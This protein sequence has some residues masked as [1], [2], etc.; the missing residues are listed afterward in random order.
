MQRRC[1]PRKREQLELSRRGTEGSSGGFGLYSG[2]PRDEGPT[3][4]R[5]LLMGPSVGPRAEEGLTPGQWRDMVRGELE[6]CPLDGGTWGRRRGSRA[7]A[8]TSGC[9]ARG[10]VWGHAQ[11]CRC[12]W[13]RARCV[14]GTDN[15][16]ARP[17]GGSGSS[18]SLCVTSGDGL[19][20]LRD[21]EGEPAR[22]PCSLLPA[23]QP[24]IGGGQRRLQ[25]PS[26]LSGSPHA[27]SLPPASRSGAQRERD[28]SYLQPLPLRWGPPRARFLGTIDAIIPGSLPQERP[29]SPCIC[30][31]KLTGNRTP[32]LGRPV[33]SRLP[34]D[35]ATPPPQPV[36]A[37]AG[38]PGGS[39]TGGRMGT[40]GCPMPSLPAGQLRFL[41]K[42]EGAQ[43]RQLGAPCGGQSA[44]SYH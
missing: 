3:G 10:G 21:R 14:A 18:V 44:L 26:A 20:Q 27:A 13:G 6:K 32:G 31:T 5:G 11:G 25:G 39:R 30:I 40:P 35:P 1:H 42:E 12:C 24:G 33:S 2:V 9:R 29:W 36:G 23:L 43:R 7:G 19:W 8:G 15:T 28:L 17:W 22:P 16:R 4:G 41:G 37:P 34:Q 38:R